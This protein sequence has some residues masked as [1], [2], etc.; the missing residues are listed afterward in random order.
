MV[1]VCLFFSTVGMEEPHESNYAGLGCVTDLEGSSKGTSGVV[2]SEKVVL[3]QH[4][5]IKTCC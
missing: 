5:I 2:F 4:A 1:R 3:V